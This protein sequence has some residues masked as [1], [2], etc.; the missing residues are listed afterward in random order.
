[1]AFWKSAFQVSCKVTA[2][3]STGVI[4]ALAVPA[5]ALYAGGKALGFDVDTPAEKIADGI[6][7]GI[8][9]IYNGGGEFFEKHSDAI[10]DTVVRTST[11][12]VTKHLGADIEHWWS[13][14]SSK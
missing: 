9:A 11:S 7:K 8:G 6:A 5:F 13:D 4:S 2:L 1:M 10:T 12:M 3:A 14:D